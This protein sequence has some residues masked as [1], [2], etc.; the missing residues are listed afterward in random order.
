M[1]V[2]STQLTGGQWIGP[3][4]R[5]QN[6]G[7]S[8]YVGIYNWNNGSPNLMLFK[9]SGGKGYLDPAGRHL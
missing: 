5:A 3:M 6:N 4:V 9:R 8:A 7:L 1:T 2:T